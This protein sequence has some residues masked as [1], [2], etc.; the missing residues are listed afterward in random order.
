M[1]N[2]GFFLQHSSI[3]LINILSQ[4]YFFFFKGKTMLLNRQAFKLGFQ[5]KT[6]GILNL[7][8]FEEGLMKEL[9]SKVGT[10]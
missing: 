5:Q 6:N 4:F 3:I 2:L 7:E 9:C 1:D 10:S 8:L